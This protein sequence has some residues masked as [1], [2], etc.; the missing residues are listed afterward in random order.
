VI[1]VKFGY[2]EVPIA[3]LNPDCV[4]GHMNELPAAVESLMVQRSSTI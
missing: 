1:G 4:I 2:T 3:D